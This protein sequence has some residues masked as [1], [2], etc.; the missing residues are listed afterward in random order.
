MNN[1]FYALIFAGLLS[2][3]SISFGYADTYDLLEGKDHNAIAAQI[4][5]AIKRHPAECA[6]IRAIMQE[7]IVLGT[8]AFIEKAPLSNEQANEAKNFCL[9]LRQQLE[10][11]PLREKSEV[12]FVFFGP[13]LNKV[14]PYDSEGCFNEFDFRQWRMAQDTF[15]C[16]KLRS[17]VI[18]SLRLLHE[19]IKRILDDMHF[20]DAALQ[21]I[22]DEMR[23]NLTFV[24]DHLE[25]AVNYWCLSWYGWRYPANYD[26]DELLSGF[27]PQETKQAARLLNEW[28]SGSPRY[29]LN[30]ALRAQLVQEADL[31]T[32]RYDISWCELPLLACYGSTALLEWH[33]ENEKLIVDR[34]IQVFAEKSKDCTYVTDCA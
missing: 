19:P 9:T 18:A 20:D 24:N 16:P 25:S 31:E 33:R 2:L 10:T 7:L 1:K 21:Q 3:T 28:W 6:E 15:L 17:Q 12:N 27:V 32:L 29:F 5:T 14:L 23:T 22:M 34:V 8:G 4:V 26:Y 30:Q 13:G 11:V